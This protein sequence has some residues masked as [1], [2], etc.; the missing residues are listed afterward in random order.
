MRFRFILNFIFLCGFASCVTASF[1]LTTFSQTSEREKPNIKDFGKS[2]REKNEIE[3]PQI[4]NAASENQSD[5]D[6]IKVETN[7]VRTDVM[8]V[9]Q[10]GKPVLGLKASDFVV[11]ENSIPQEIGTFS[12][13]DSAEV[14]RSIVLIIDYSGSQIPYIQTSVDAAKVLVDKLNPKDR[15]AIV[16]DD[17]ELL[18]EFTK[19]K[20]FLKNKLDSLANKVRKGEAGKSLQYSRP[21]L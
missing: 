17:V 10:K 4:N 11:T 20:E 21:H 12:L 9:D 13:G 1:V 14:P 2:L 15:M 16:T 3:K 19:D 7:L 8:V 6:V 18:A 5:E